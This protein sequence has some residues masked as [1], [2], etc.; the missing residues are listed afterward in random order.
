[1]R[2]KPTAFLVALAAACSL[3]PIAIANEPV[4]QAEPA[5][6]T[7]PEVPHTS[8]GVGSEERERLEAESHRYNLKVT[9]AA[10]AN[11]PFLADV[12]VVIR[13]EGG[14]KVLEAV[15]GGPWFYAKL[16]PGKYRVS[17]TAA[18][19]TQEQSAQAPAAG[20]AKLAFY[21]REVTE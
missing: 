16:P 17:A 2:I 14:T 7:A 21:W 9:F 11:A 15:S 19:K 6:Q 20:Q 18:G 1:M 10:T 4:D 5:V 3:P 13:D 12:P 8:G